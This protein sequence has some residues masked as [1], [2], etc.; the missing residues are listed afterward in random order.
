MTVSSFKIIWDGIFQTPEVL[1]EVVIGGEE[2]IEGQEETPLISIRTSSD[3][4]GRS[5]TP[6]TINRLL[7]QHRTSERFGQIHLD[8]FEYNTF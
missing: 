3:S 5:R 7:E 1:G 4:S 8:D 6:R 2:E